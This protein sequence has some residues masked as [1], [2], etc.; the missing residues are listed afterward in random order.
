VSIKPLPLSFFSYSGSY[1]RDLRFVRSISPTSGNQELTSVANLAAAR[2][3]RLEQLVHL[4]VAH[5]LAQV[6][7]DV[8][9]L[10][11]ADEARHILVKH[12]EAAAVLLR[13][14]WVAESAGAVQYAGKGVEID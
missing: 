6:G 4:L 11:D 13:L 7:Q 8:S 9:Q 2:V 3:H 1:E 12:L 10:P 14:A 5:L